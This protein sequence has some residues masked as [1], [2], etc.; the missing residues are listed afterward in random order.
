MYFFPESLS[1]EQCYKE[2]PFPESFSNS[3]VIP[4]GNA[5]Y[6]LQNVSEP[7]NSA[8]IYLDRKRI[9]AHD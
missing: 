9:L 1:I 2:L 6:C 4:D 8:V 7:S 5:L 3:V